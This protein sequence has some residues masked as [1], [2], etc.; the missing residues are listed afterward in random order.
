MDCSPTGPSV[1]PP[2][3]MILCSLLFQHDR[4]KKKNV[5]VCLSS[6]SSAD[7]SDD[8]V[9]AAKDSI[10]VK[11]LLKLIQEGERLSPSCKI[12]RIT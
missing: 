11:I 9:E 3:Q 2:P 6:W 12:R 4:T 10:F 5:F 8:P 7:G 1:L